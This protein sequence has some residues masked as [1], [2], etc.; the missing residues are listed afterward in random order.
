M[1]VGI[2]VL[3]RFDDLAGK[4]VLP[5]FEVIVASVEECLVSARGEKGR[6]EM[7]R[8]K[9]KRIRRVEKGG[10]GTHWPTLLETEISG[11]VSIDRLY[12]SRRS[13]ASSSPEACPSTHRSERPSFYR[14]RANTRRFRDPISL[15]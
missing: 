2:W 14:R 3:G 7:R 13:N 5:R 11:L 10:K 9:E 6:E 4:E 15:I 1:S 12:L 8:E